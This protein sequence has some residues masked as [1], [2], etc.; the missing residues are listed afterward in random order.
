MQ[1][2]PAKEATLQ[3]ARFRLCEHETARFGVRCAR[4]DEVTLAD[5]AAIF[6][7]TEEARID[8]LMLRCSAREL[9]V[10]HY[11]E[12]S[13][14]RLMDT[15]LYTGVDL[16]REPKT[17]ELPGVQY[18]LATANDSARVGD[19]AALAF[20]NYCSHYHADPRLS[21]LDADS[22]YRE[23]AERSCVDTSVANRVVLAENAGELLGF[24]AI[25]LTVPGEADGALFA[26]APSA[27]GRGIFRSLL[28]QALTYS[29]QTGLERFT[30][31]TQIQYLAA[32]RTISGMGFEI[33]GAA[34]IF[35]G[36][37][38]SDQSRAHLK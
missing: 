12:R 26:V 17:P 28:W 20:R 22:V 25:R 15:I 13:G 34:Y 16:S 23:W 38:D 11:V 29:R 14:F 10:V 33:K 18:R 19:L 2:Q 1:A 6:R 32:L 8:L 36:W 3:T 35:H 4:A 5:V 21:K 37:F 9:D 31:S 7:L 30:Y 24:G 27:Q